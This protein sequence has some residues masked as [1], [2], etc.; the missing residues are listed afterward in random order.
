MSIHR[1]EFA[2]W[3]KA[4]GTDYHFCS[5]CEALHLDVLKSQD[6]VVDCRLFVEP[7][8][9]LLTTE[10]ELRPTALLPITADLGRLNMDYPTLKL[11][12]DVI[13]EAMPQLVASA[14]VMTAG[15]YNEAQFGVFIEQALR[16]TS[17]LAEECLQL[18]YL[19]LERPQNPD[20][21]NSPHLH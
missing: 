8:G 3:L 5:E 16:A 21:G 19:L 20:R 7:W 1:D 11:F 17:Q 15:G 2:N 14:T 9:L 13:D 18:D 10:L 12:T 6:G 4:S